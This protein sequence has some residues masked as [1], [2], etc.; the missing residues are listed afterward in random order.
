M[1]LA[2]DHRPADGELVDEA[3]DAALAHLARVVCL[4]GEQRQVED[5]RGRADGLLDALDAAVREE[6]PRLAVV[7]QSHLRRPLHHAD[8]PAQLEVDG[9]LGGDD[10]AVVGQLV[11]RAEQGLNHLLGG[12]LPGDHRAEGQVY[13]A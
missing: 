6:E 2:P 5:G 3:G 7:Q 11:Q 12:H 10:H 4:L 9:C 13:R 1:Q 8:V